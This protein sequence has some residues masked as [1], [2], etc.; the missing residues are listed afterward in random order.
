MTSGIPAP[1]LG[2]RDKRDIDKEQQYKSRNK[3]QVVTLW[4]LGLISAL[5]V[6]AVTHLEFLNLD[7]LMFTDY[8]TK[9]S[10]YTKFDFSPN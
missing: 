2:N 7:F 3:C 4:L 8:P 9:F 6:T 10:G 1:D 5:L